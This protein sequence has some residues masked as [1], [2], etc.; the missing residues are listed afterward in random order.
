M[1]PC[2]NCDIS[3]PAKEHELSSR[4][5][6]PAATAVPV[7]GAVGHLDAAAA[8][9]KKIAA[10]ER[11]A[12]DSPPTDL[13]GLGR[14]SAAATPDDGSAVGK[15][16]ELDGSFSRDSCQSGVNSSEAVDTIS[17]GELPCF[18]DLE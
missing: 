8:E 18:K 17:E 10:E 11:L 1:D 14:K 5:L 3:P 4:E 2:V 16:A 12:G 6:T 13:P 9:S 15:A 7:G